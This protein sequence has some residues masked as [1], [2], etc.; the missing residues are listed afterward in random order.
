MVEG[1]DNAAVEL[2]E[3]GVNGFIA[4]SV[5]DL[6][7]AIVAVHRAGSSLRES[8]LRWFAANA[9]RLSVTES[10]DRIAS[11]YSE[12]STQPPARARR[13]WL[14]RSASR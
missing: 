12:A 5:D 13:A 11:E 2:I 8:T 1:A 6:P 14:R 7:G 4:R 10:A 3:E 9:P